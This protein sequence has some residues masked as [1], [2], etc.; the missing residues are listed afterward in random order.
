MHCD[1]KS[2]NILLDDNF[3]PKI[4]DFGLAKLMKAEQTRTFTGGRG[5]KGYIA[6]EWHKNMAI[7]VKVDVYSFGVMLLEIICCRKTIKL[8]ALKKEM[9]LS[10]WVYDCLKHNSLE[11]LME[12]Q[13]SEGIVI[14]SSQLERMVLVGLWC[15]QEN[16][17][18]RPSMKKVVQMLEG[19]VEIPLPP[20]PESFISLL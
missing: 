3:N 20:S 15:I 19:T 5:T 10:E 4:A 17:S 14:D 16:P 9:F 12:K 1:I 13:R 18:L 11:K 8:D 6:P 2:Q 7:T